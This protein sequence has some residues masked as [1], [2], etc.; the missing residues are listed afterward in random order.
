MIAFGCSIVTPEIYEARAKA[1]FDR[2][3]EPGSAILALAAGGSL[4]RSYNLLLGRAAELPELEALVLVHEDAEITDDR[5]CTKLRA[6]LEDPDVGVVGCTGATGVRDLAWW[7]GA[8]TWNSAKYVYGEFGGGELRWQPDTVL[9]PGEVD[10][11]YGVLMALTPWVVQ[12]LR[13]DESVGVSHG[14]DFDICSKAREAGRK[15]VAADLEVAHHHALDVVEETE[16]WVA[17]H[18]R[19]AELWDRSGPHDPADPAWKLR[20]RQAEAAAAAARLL[21]A[22]ELLRL[23]AT[24]NQHARQQR[25]IERSRSWRLTAS[26]R[27]GNALRRSARKRIGSVLRRAAR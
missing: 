25:D 14:Y 6:A 8:V 21:A 20:A 13:F 18:M 9:A 2:A 26:L 4:A 15:V 19:A 16:I 7:D 23:D 22:S 27:R 12:N 11:V 17:A 24:A 1:G 5:F 10:S 3:A